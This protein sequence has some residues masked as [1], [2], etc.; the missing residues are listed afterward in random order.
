M[1]EGRNRFKTTWAA[2]FFDPL[3]LKMITAGSIPLPVDNSTSAGEMP[4]TTPTK[5]Q[6]RSS[7]SD[8]STGSTQPKMSLSE[9]GALGAQ[10]RKQNQ[11][12]QQG[13]IVSG[14]A[15]DFSHIPQGFEYAQRLQGALDHLYAIAGQGWPGPQQQ[16]ASV[17][18][19]TQTAGQRKAGRPRGSKNKPTTSQG[20]TTA[21]A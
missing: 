9:R 5:G 6:T 12:A 17:S 19:S 15:R 7:A 3:P 13:L 1:I 21:T 18:A 2:N 20:G 14:A 4:M 8:E 16:A 10:V 11:M